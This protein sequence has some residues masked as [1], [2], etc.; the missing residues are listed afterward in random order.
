MNMKRSI[1]E[2]RKLIEVTLADM[3]KTG[4]KVNVSTVARRIGINH[5]YIHNDFPDLKLKSL[6]PK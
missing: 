6:L 2:T 3:V 5:S 4:D 1:D